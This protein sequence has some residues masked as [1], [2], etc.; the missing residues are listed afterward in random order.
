MVANENSGERKKQ[1]SQGKIAG[2]RGVGDPDPDP[3]PL[4]FPRSPG[5]RRT[6]SLTEGLEQAMIA[7]VNEIKSS[8]GNIYVTS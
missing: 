3:D 2:A 5:A 1:A 4:I 7:L 8:V 6:G